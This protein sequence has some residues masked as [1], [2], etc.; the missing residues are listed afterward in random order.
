MNKLVLSLAVV[1]PSLLHAGNWPGWRGPNGDGT[2]LETNLPIKWSRTENIAWRLELPGPAGSTPAVWEDRIF[3]TSPAG[4][5]L[6]LLCVSRGGKE[7]WRR[8]VEAGNK[9]F[10]GDE[11]NSAA[12][13]PST[14]GKHVWAFFGTGHL[15]CFDF[16]GQIV[17]QSNL[18]DLYG[19]YDH[20]HG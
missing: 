18:K 14:D 9:D 2:S 10:R 20:W 16:E 1:L 19:D 8:K 3:L 11:G 12:P 7:L 6:V 4:D 13:S 15:A 5:D 17:W